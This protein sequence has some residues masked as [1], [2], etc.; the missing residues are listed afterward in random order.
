MSQSNQSQQSQQSQ[1]P[2]TTAEVSLSPDRACVGT[3]PE[4]S[5]DD[6]CLSCPRREARDARLTHE[7]IRRIGRNRTSNQRHLLTRFRQ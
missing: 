3:C 2:H 7:D 6:F 5:E 4:A 1:Q